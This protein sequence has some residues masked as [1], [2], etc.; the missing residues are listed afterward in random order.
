MNEYVGDLIDEEECKRRL[1][2]AHEEDIRNFYMMTLD[3]DRSALCLTEEY[4][5]LFSDNRP[6]C[7]WLCAQ[8]DHK[9]R[10]AIKINYS[11]IHFLS[12]C[13]VFNHTNIEA[14]LVYKILF[15]IKSVMINLLK[16]KW[17][18][19]LKKFPLASVNCFSVTLL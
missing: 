9:C 17:I 6:G 18:Y 11:F 13:F 14:K 16:F 3:S 12:F 8:N 19:L 7:L 1:E 10:Q 5:Y 4:R 15:Q 2:K